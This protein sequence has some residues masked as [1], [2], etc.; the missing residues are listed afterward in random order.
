MLGGKLSGK[1]L[2]VLIFLKKISD[3]I[4]AYAPAS[5]AQ[6]MARRRSEVWRTHFKS[7]LAST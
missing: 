4:T 7:F 1:L 3:A 6:S 5:V 2:T